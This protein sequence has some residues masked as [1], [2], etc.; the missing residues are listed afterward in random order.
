MIQISCC[1]TTNT[2]PTYIHFCC[3]ESEAISGGKSLRPRLLNSHPVGALTG[4]C[5]PPSLPLQKKK[6]CRAPFLRDK[7][8]VT[9]VLQSHFLCLWHL[10]HSLGLGAPWD[11]SLQQQQKPRMYFLNAVL[12]FSQ[13]TSYD[14]RCVY[15][16]QLSLWHQPNW[17]ATQ[18]PPVDGGCSQTFL[19]PKVL[20]QKLWIL[21]QFWNPLDTCEYKIFISSVLTRTF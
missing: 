3:W 10:Y 11:C 1:K 6:V 9:C 7:S 21:C 15:L 5:H 13:A 2:T 4:G 20:L 14:I 16:Q 12:F 17:A 8:D 19:L 18:H